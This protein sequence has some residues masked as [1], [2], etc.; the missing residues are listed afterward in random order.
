MKKQYFISGLG[1]DENAFQKL[2]DFGTTKIMVNW[3]KNLPNETL[4]NYSQRLITKYDIKQ[5]DIIVGLSFGGMVAQQIAQILNSEFIILISSFRTKNDLKILFNKSLNLKLHKLIPEF[6][7]P[8]IDELIAN[9]LNSGSSLSK[10]VLKEMI[11]QTDLKLM[12]WSIEKI[13]EQ[14]SQ[15][16]ENV[17]KYN[18]IG[19]KD[20]IVKTWKNETTFIIENGSHFMVFDKA[21]EVSN[22]INQ[23]LN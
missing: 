8:I 3:I 13:Y 14:E 7:P 18:L 20:K 16:A 15:L 12:K 21:V 6:K 5:E 19:N 9:Y 22:F 10:P 2:D 17:K 1:A 11:E 4:E 23:I